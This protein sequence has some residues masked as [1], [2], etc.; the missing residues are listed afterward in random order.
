[1]TRYDKRR[2]HP[3]FS[4]DI[5]VAVTVADVKLAARTRD[6]SRAGLCLI[7]DQAIPADTEIGLEL[8]LTFG[9]AGTSEP[10]QMAGRVAWC[11]ALFGAYQIGV[12]FI[13]VDSEQERYLDMFIG[14]L[15]GTLGPGDLFS[16]E[17]ASMADPDD[18]FAA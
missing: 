3:R 6:M 18:P 15:D 5:K 1:M 11:T 16:G 2:E 14:F 7:A 17:E 12:K 8:V 13:K 4:V 9:E 10:L